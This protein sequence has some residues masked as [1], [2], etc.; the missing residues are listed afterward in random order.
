M[1][2]RWAKKEG[3]VVL[4]AR[5]FGR[6]MV[7]KIIKPGRDGPRRYCWTDLDSAGQ[8]G[9]SSFRSFIPEH[10]GV[11]A[12]RRLNFTQVSV[13][14]RFKSSPIFARQRTGLHV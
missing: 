6:I 3:N 5:G 10:F 12:S 14:L 9:Y 2:A 13:M 1:E 11:D 7:G 4:D 8:G